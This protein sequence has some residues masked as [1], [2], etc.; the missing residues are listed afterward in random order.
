MGFESV[1]YPGDVL[2]YIMESADLFGIVV[3]GRR[4]RTRCGSLR[5]V[6]RFSRCTVVF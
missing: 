3:T 4:E 1:D 5:K 2:G 6:G